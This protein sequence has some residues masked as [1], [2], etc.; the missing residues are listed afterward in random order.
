MVHIRLSEEAERLVKNYLK[1]EKQKSYTFDFF[2]DEKNYI[3]WEDVEIGMEAWSDKEFEVKEEDIESYL[4]ATENNC[5]VFLKEGIA[6]PMFLTT[7]AF[8]LIGDSFIGSWIKT[9]GAINPGQKI[10]FCK[11]IRVGDVIRVKMKAYDKF[12]KRGKRYLTYY[13]EFV[14]QRGEIVAKWW[15]TLIL[16]ISRSEE[17]HKIEGVRR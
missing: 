4:E 13:N 15:G 3:K 10:E 2:I 12:I 16:P 11:P 9:P 8:W 6:P 7:I 14:N 1:T 17:E 5:S